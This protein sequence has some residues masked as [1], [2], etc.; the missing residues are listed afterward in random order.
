[1]PINY[2]KPLIVRDSRNG[3]WF[4]VDKEVWQDKTLTASDKVVYGTLAYFAN[5]KDQ[6]AFPS[7]TTLEE[8][9]CISRRQIYISIKVLENRK[10]LVVV[11]N[12]GKP[13]EYTLLKMVTKVNGRTSAESALVQN[14]ACTSAESALVQIIAWSSAASAPVLVQNTASNKNDTEQELFNK[15]ILKDTKQNFGNGDINF[16]ISYFKENLKLPLLDGS[17]KENRR[18]CWLAIKKFG[19]REGVGNLIKLT[20]A[21]D[22]WKSKITSFKDM[23]YRGVRIVSE[24]RGGV[25]DVRAKYAKMGE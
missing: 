18:Y 17:E 15:S 4:W 19:G 12:R 23:Y 11:R 2:D 8:Y 10:Y 3:S 14:T 24:T 25:A 7:I 21:H 5:Q 9:S 6:T 20:A 13:N 16:L 22:F 1:M